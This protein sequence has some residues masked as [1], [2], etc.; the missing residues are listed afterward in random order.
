MR[1]QCANKLVATIFIGHDD[2][3]SSGGFKV[4]QSNCVH[5]HSGDPDIISG[6][7]ISTHMYKSGDNIK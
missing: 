4:H 6:G 2:T 5:P 3:I 7:I 1:V